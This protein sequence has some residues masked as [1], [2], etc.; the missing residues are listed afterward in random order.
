MEKTKKR[1]LLNILSALVPAFM[2]GLSVIATSISLASA[3][4][5]PTDENFYFIYE[6]PDSHHKYKCYKVI[7]EDPEDTSKFVSISWLIDSE[8]NPYPED[9]INIPETVS[10]G[11]FN[12]T[13]K[14]I[15]KAGFRRCPTVSINV[16]NTVVEIK[17]EAFAYC[18]N[19]TD[20][21]FP[22]QLDEIA[23]S[24]FLDCREL[25]TL[26]YRDSAGN[27]AITNETIEKIGDHAFDSCVKLKNFYCPTTVTE[28][29]R[30]CFQRCESIINF[31][32]PVKNSDLEHYTNDITV[33]AYAFADCKKLNY[34]YFEE[35]MD[36]IEHH[37]FANCDP[38][39]KIYYTGNSN[40]TYDASWRDKKITS[41]DTTVY[42]IINNQTEIRSDISYPGLYFTI[43]SG[44]IKLDSAMDNTTTVYFNQSE[45]EYA[46]I[47]KFDAPFE[48]VENYYN[49]ETG[50]LT[51]PNTIKGK[52]LKVINEN[53][54]QNNLDLRAVIFNKDLVQIKHGAFYHCTNIAN[55]DFSACTELKEI[56]YDVFQEPIKPHTN[57]VYNEALTELHLP[58]CLEYLGEFAFYNFLNLGGGANAA[59]AITFGGE[60]SQLKVIG[61][62]AFAVNR[63]KSYTVS[64]GTIDLVLPCSLNDYYART[65]VSNYKHQHN[66][67]DSSRWIDIAYKRPY[68]IGTHAFDN[69]KR[70]N[71]VTMYECNHAAH[72]GTS[73]YTTSLA[74]NGFIR[75]E[76]M[77]RFKANSNLCYIGKDNFKTIALREIFLTTAK[78]EANATYQYPWGI[79]DNADKYGETLFWGNLTHDIVIYV[80]GQRAPKNNDQMI[81]GNDYTNPNYWNSNSA[82]GGNDNK[83]NMF[84][85]ELGDTQRS[86]LPTFY[87][88][89]YFT[90]SN[91]VYYKPTNSGIVACDAPITKADYDNGLIAFV[92]DEVTEKYTC[93]KYWCNTNTS[94]Q[95]IDLS[96]I[97]GISENLIDIGDEAFASGD[98]GVQA[99][100][101]I[102]LPRT[103]QRISER[104]FFRK[105]SSKGLRIVTYRKADN[106]IAV[107]SGSAST[108]ATI[109]AGCTSADNGDP[110]LCLPPSLTYLGRN[111]FYNNR[112]ESI[113]LAPN[114][115]YIGNCALY[116]SG[117]RM[118]TLNGAFDSSTPFEKINNG[119]YYSESDGNGGTNKILLYQDGG[120]GGTL[121]IDPNTVAIGY[122]G[123]VNTKYTKITLP[124][125]LINIYGGGLQKNN[126]VT[127]I[128]GAG[129]SSLVYISTMFE[130]DQ[131]I[132]KNAANVDDYGDHF[133]NYE[134]RKIVNEADKVKQNRQGAFK[135]CQLLATMNFMNMTSVKYIGTSA[136][137]G[138][139][140]LENMTGNSTYAFYHC[141]HTTNSS[142]GG[143]TTVNATATKTDNAG[144]LDLTN[145]TS[146]LHIAG[147]AFS[148]CS[149]ITYVITRDTT[150]DSQRNSDGIRTAESQIKYGISNTELSTGSIFDGTS[151]EILIGE[152]ASQAYPDFKVSGIN[153]NVQSHYKSGCFGTGNYYYYTNRRADVYT[154]NYGLK[155]WTKD[156][157]GNY[158]LFDNGY[159][160]SDYFRVLGI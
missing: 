129:L 66:G 93:A 65:D 40:P 47:Y 87:N 69:Q 3:I 136:F 39:M 157:S 116:S 41:A 97:S 70:I 139:K 140:A 112:F 83:L 141:T 60:N 147:G 30:S 151:R 52:K 14:S 7:N 117:N 4:I 32:F 121:V 36:K 100:Y 77:I 50:T 154:G 146:L 34:V 55:L 61:A 104:A 24:T 135:G 27:R 53:T 68:A 20:F 5:L 144:V 113:D 152:T 132:W 67:M 37:A 45:E 54:F 8:N 2:V 159:Q 110:Y 31:F 133:D 89:D 81:V 111:A 71:T 88:I 82:M 84:L 64:G 131:Q 108:Y 86:H 46:Q 137:N 124:G 23:P 105:D 63:N 160:A 62:Y 148:G 149:K 103:L 42:D 72:T 76:N 10:D 59:N 102:I 130:D 109:K 6:D 153:T 119:I 44:K 1:K 19:L 58:A 118:T 122:R 43:E 96:N 38:E 99:G 22:Y 9:V 134:Y 18:Q 114:I 12:Y 33:E 145:C 95:E 128:D 78:A 107:P 21:T 91:V 15:A 127:E 94:Y 92:K 150:G 125:S 16:P 26:A 98:R 25:T 120:N 115:T 123:C 138:C 56:G 51:L 28:F 143:T 155:Y 142:L 106:S 74:S 158:I 13:V 73:S 35:N 48:T 101:F 57:E 75:C 85:N 29:G 79:E 156:G 90:G 17:Q 11:E 80:N 126:K 49:V